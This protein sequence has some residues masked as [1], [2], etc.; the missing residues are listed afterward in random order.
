MYMYMYLPHLLS[1]SLPAW[2][3]RLLGVAGVDLRR[4]QQQGQG[5]HGEEQ[6][7][8]EEGGHGEEEGAPFREA[9]TWAVASWDGRGPRD[10]AALPLLV[11]GLLPALPSGQAGLAAAVF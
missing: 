10:Q 9:A 3:V 11:G 6:G 7:G 8:E 2:V 1:L 4:P 5:G